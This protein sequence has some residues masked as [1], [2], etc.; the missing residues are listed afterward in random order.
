MNNIPLFPER[1]TDLAC[2][3]ANRAKGNVSCK[4]AH[5]CIK[6]NFAYAANQLYLN[7]S[8]QLH[9]AC[10]HMALSRLLSQS[11]FVLEIVQQIAQFL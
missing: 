4:G 6:C 9:A 10:I 7:A 2:C 1:Q 8:V 5:Q 3:H 11:T